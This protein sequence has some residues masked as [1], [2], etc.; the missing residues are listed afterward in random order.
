MDSREAELKRA[1]K[2]IR[3]RLDTESA[4]I[5]E[6]RFGRKIFVDYVIRR[7][8]RRAGLRSS[9]FAVARRI[10]FAL[11]SAL[12]VL[13][14]V[15]I[16]RRHRPIAFQ[17][18]SDSGPLDSSGNAGDLIAANTV[19]PTALRF[20]EGSSIV[21]ERAAQVRV[22]SLNANGARVLI[23]KGTADVAIAHPGGPG[24]WRFEAGPVTVDVTG[25]RFRIDWNPDERSF[26]IELKEGSV[27]VGGDCLQEPRK[28]Q[29]GDSLRL[30]CSGPV[31]LDH[32]RPREDG[33]ALACVIDASTGSDARN[34]DQC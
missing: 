25:T 21:L 7:N 10:S 27:I 15:L 6:L 13:V 18:D 29:R 1:G 24:K 8:T 2:M 12:A 17:I 11:A 19:A 28:V 31:P 33:R 30:S 5:E 22:L 16:W 20:S 14:G 26:G 9:R 4:E 32:A 23:E 3:A 34:C